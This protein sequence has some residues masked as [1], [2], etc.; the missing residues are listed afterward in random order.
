MKKHYSL[1]ND[2]HTLLLSEEPTMA[3][4]YIHCFKRNIEVV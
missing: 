1:N 2:I 4:V 3:I